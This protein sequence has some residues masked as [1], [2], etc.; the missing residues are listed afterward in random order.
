[1]SRQELKPFREVFVGK[2]F[3]ALYLQAH[4]D[5]IYHIRLGSWRQEKIELPS[6]FNFK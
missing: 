4:L 3:F 2:T 1:M 6:S 5:L